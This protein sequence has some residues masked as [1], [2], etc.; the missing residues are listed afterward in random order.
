[1]LRFIC[2]VGLMVALIASQPAPEALAEGE[3]TMKSETIIPLPQPRTGGSV[4][5]EETLSERRSVR[6]FR[7]EPVAL[8]EV[9][10]LLWAAQGVTHGDGMRTA[11]SAGALYPLE[12]YAVAA[13]V[14]GL[15]PGI[16][17]YEPWRHQL[18]SV[19]SGD[20][21]A[22]IA[23]A[24]LGQDW[25]EDSAVLLIFGAVEARTARKYGPRAARYVHMEIGHAAQ[26]VFLQAAALG[27]GGT[28]VGAFDDDRL[29]RAVGMSSDEQ[30]LY[31]VPI[32]K[33]RY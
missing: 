6:E 32:G 8:S 33:P 3:M 18:R 10:Q 19:R 16:Y 11:P 9:S 25:L 29:A 26:N 22:A 12:L 17:R 15:A 31:I 13:N 21:R 28:P 7:K 30:A 14:Q 4:S 27:L 23:A 24:A 5:L 1:M 20:F 2:V